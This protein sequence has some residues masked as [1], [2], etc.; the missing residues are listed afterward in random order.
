MITPR[1][2]NANWYCIATLVPHVGVDG[3]KCVLRLHKV[4]NSVTKGD[5]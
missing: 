5:N 1:F 4:L 2:V 3:T